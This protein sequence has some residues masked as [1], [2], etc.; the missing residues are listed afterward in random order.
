LVPVY[1][2][3]AR[4]AWLIR[5]GLWLYDLLAVKGHGLIRLHRWLKAPQALAVAADLARPGL[6]G[7]AEYWDC[8]MDDARVT[9]ENV[10]DAQTHGCQALNYC[11]LV[12]A[13]R[14]VDGDVELRLRDEESGAEATAQGG[15]LLL[16]AGAWTDEVLAA[17]GFGDQPPKVHPTKGIHLVTRRLIDGHALLVPARSDQRIFFVIPWELEGRPASLIGTTD[18]D[19]SGD[20]NHP[21]AEAEEIDYL[22]SEARRVLPESKLERADL[23]STFAGLRPLTAAPQKGQGNAAVSR[24]HTFWSQ[25]GILAVTGGKFTTYRSLCQA[26]VEKAAQ[27]LGRPLGPSTSASRPLPG[28]PLNGE[29]HGE[30]LAQELS[31]STGLA[32][33]ATRLLV[34]HYGRRARSVAALCRQQPSWAEALAPGLSPAP[35]AMLAWAALEEHAVHLDDVY[36][37]RSRLGLRLSPDHPGVERGAAVMGSILGWSPQRVREELERLGATLRAEYR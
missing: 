36:L 1:A 8:Q 2:G 31:R 18:S 27:R 34:G 13:S 29:A 20:K 28:A 21:H 14:L 17:L 35:L 23:W 25:P 37:R 11:S 26:L 7:A 4:P 12:G 24:E 5:S 32:L 10:L 19:Y 3:D 15:L 6:Q 30:A 33:D 9:L 16:A 22:L